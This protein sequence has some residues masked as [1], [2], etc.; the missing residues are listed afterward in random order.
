[1]P[2]CHYVAKAG[3]E[4]HQYCIILTW[5]SILASIVESGNHRLWGWPVYRAGALFYFILLYFFLRT[6]NQ[7]FFAFA[8]ES[9]RVQPQLLVPCR[10]RK[11]SSVATQTVAQGPWTVRLSRRWWEGLKDKAQKSVD[12]PKDK[13]ERGHSFSD[14]TVCRPTRQGS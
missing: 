9:Y 10:Q 1:M 8:Q 7:N 12:Y 2:T 13:A 5:A 6:W 3:S 4:R 14:L 11:I